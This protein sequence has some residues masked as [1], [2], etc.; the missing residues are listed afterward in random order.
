MLCQGCGTPNDPDDEYCIKCQQKLLVVSGNL[1]VAD[2]ELEGA[3]EEA[4]SF[5]EHLLERISVL[6]EA[7]R[8]TAE[9]LQRVLSALNKQ[10]RNILIN[11]SGLQ[12]LGEVLEAKEVV[13]DEEWR[14]P[15]KAQL[16]SQLL[17]L[18]KRQSFA[19]IKDRMV[20]LYRGEQRAEFARLLDDA[21]FALYA[22]DARRALELLQTAFEMDRRNYEL[23]CFIGET[24]FNEGEAGKALAYFAQL[25]EVKPEH[26]QGLVYSGVILHERGEV[27]EA[28]DLLERAVEIYPQSFL[29]LF[30]LGAVYA[31]EGELDRAARYLELAVAIEPVP[32]ACFLLG[33]ARYELG[34]LEAAIAGLEEAVRHE[35]AF[36]EAHHLLGLAYLDRG[37]T[38]RALDSFRRAQQLNPK[39]LRYGDLV[40][41]LSG[42]ASSPLAE[43][44]RSAA[45]LLE[46]AE[47]EL[48]GDE[49]EQALA[50]YREALES[51]PANPTLLISYAMACLRLEDSGEAERAVRELL[52]R[53]PNEMLRATAYA[54]LIE[55]L[56]N[57]GRYSEGNGF[58]ER[59]L[60]EGESEFTKTIAYYEMAYNLA[61]MEEDLDRALDYAR[62]S[63]EHSPEE[64]RQFPLA[65]LGWV[66]YKRKEFGRAIDC[67]AQS[68]ELATS[69]TTLTHLG[70][71][72]LAT[73]EEDHAR[74]VLD[75]ARRL[76][77]GVDSVEQKLME[78]L[79][80]SSRL[81]ERVQ[82]G[83][84]K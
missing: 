50:L 40:R 82:R 32:Q 2:V 77:G 19:A 24:H 29:P 31:G 78:C 1:L 58:G 55:A 79:K 41:Y 23:A 17:A 7:V 13:T 84:R 65:A 43:V 22:L 71:A 3:D 80:D 37:W 42:Q 48:E 6:E 46:K 26:Y 34:E 20:A 16:D 25:L 66:Y 28:L 70:M 56:R 27:A 52:D 63:L 57:E 11:H 49:P 12:A 59:L 61:E 72:L 68:T 35:P 33:S 4:V 39:K 60:A 76:T 51:E 36:E 45:E 73:G 8:R 64:L 44:G 54:T 15:W 30:S 53:E 62:R 9:T 18:E 74:E 10:E 69:A 21:E 67:L 47:G 83:Q 75:E 5:D 38:R 81:H 14:Q